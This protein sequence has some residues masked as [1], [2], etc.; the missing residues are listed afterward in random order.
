MRDLKFRAWHKESKLMYWFDVM[1]GNLYG[2]GSGYIGMVP[3]GKTREY[4]SFMGG[5]TRTEIDPDNCEIMQYTDLKDKN[6]KE[7][8]EGDILADT[9][10]PDEYYTLGKVAYCDTPDCIYAGQFY[11]QGIEGYAS[12]WDGIEPENWHGFEVIGNIYENPELLEVKN[13]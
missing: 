2:S 11:I 1:W 7:I 8:Y 9:D 12:D 3:I 5:D 6:G 4:I 13:G 10:C